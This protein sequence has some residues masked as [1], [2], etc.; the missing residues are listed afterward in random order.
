[1]YQL[2]IKKG[3]KGVLGGQLKEEQI[4]SIAFG[5]LEP[6]IRFMNGKASYLSAEGAR[7]IEIK[8]VNVAKVKLVVSKIYESNLL[9]ANRYGYYPKES[10]GVTDYDE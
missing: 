6:S 10:N 5:E 1:S 3:L 2:E 8:I 4:E 9:A 7:N